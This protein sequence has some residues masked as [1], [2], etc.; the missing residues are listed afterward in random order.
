L[1][2]RS[3]ESSSDRQIH[4]YPIKFVQF[5]NGRYGTVNN[6]LIPIAENEIKASLAADI[7]SMGEFESSSAGYLPPPS[8][9]SRDLVL[10]VEPAAKSPNEPRPATARGPVFSRF[11]FAAAAALGVVVAVAGALFFEDQQQA[12]A[13]AERTAETET[14]AHTIKSLK[15]RLDA[16][17]TT[18]S[19][20]GLADLRQ[21]VGEIKSTAVSTREMSGTLAQ[22]SQR[23]D[24]L[25]H[26]ASAKVEKL[27]ERVDHEASAVTTGLSTRIDRLEQKIATPPPTPV[28]QPKQASH[29]KFDNVSMDKTGSIE[30]PRPLLHGY[31]VL[32]ARDDVALVG[33]RFGER[34][35]RQGDFLPGAGRVE[36]IEL[37]GNGWVVT[38]SSG[39]IASADFPRY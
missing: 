32:D 16:I 21:S 37:G 24:K 13:L 3:S 33:G 28:A 2:L 39:L 29:P 4:R 30:R 10:V 38:T 6:S 19:N 34:E 27:T 8:S 7:R 11:H 14:L 25:D 5:P 23:V 12:K 17:D 31:V 9:S 22:L 35:V 20:A 15:V 36:R 1:P 26:E 18:M